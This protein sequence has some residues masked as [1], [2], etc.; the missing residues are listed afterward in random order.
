ML[1]SR[2][3]VIDYLGKWETTTTQQIQSQEG[4]AS[5]TQP[6]KF[7]VVVL[8]RVW[9]FIYTNIIG[10]INDPCAI[11]LKRISQPM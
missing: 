8:L 2:K 4:C 6:K 5:L 7:K 1:A 11:I 10:I 9:K 3:T